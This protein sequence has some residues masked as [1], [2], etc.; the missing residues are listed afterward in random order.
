[1]CI[2]TLSQSRGDSPRRSQRKTGGG[3]SFPRLVHLASAGDEE[4]PHAHARRSSRRNGSSSKRVRFEKSVI[5]VVDSDDDDDDR[6]SE[7]VN[8]SSDYSME[9]A[10]ESHQVLLT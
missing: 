1:M 4:E 8:D 7:I 6:A 5:D 3:A 10:G 9:E 2:G